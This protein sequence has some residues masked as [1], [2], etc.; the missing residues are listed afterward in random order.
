MLIMQ[1]RRDYQVTVDG[2]LARWQAGLAGRPD[3]T[4]RVYDADDHMFFAGAGKSAPADYER[5]RHVD[6]AVVADIAGW[7]VPGGGKGPIARLISGM[8][9]QAPVSYGWLRL[10]KF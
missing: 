4:I 2:D 8:R 9:R 3:V 6:A 5:P 1:G 10:S 7:L